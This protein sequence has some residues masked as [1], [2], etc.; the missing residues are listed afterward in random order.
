MTL[1]ESTE[2]F[3]EKLMGGPKVN[4]RK[5]MMWLLTRW[6][7]ISDGLFSESRA[8]YEEDNATDIP[9]P[10][11]DKSVHGLYRSMTSSSIV[12]HESQYSPFEVDMTP[13]NDKHY[14]PFAQSPVVRCNG[15][16]SIS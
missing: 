13:R 9:S 12:P 5:V 6:P 7:R 16:L 15:R 11:C 1:E 8:A 4:S 2:K 3:A 14:P 10:V